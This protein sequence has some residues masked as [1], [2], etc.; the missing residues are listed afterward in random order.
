M[1]YNFETLLENTKLE[2]ERQKIESSR[3]KDD[4]RILYPGEVGYVKFR[5][6]YN[7][8]S[9]RVQREIIRH[10]ID[11]KKI[12]CLTMYGEEC[13][14]CKAVDDI[15]DSGS[16]DK[17]FRIYGRKTRGICY[18][19]FFGGSDS[20]SIG[21]NSYKD[22]ELVLMMYPKSVYNDLNKII[23]DSG[24]HI[25]DLVAN[26]ESVLLKL[27]KSSV[28]DRISYSLQVS[29]FDKRPSFSSTDEFQFFLEGIGDITNSV[30]PSILTEEILSEANAAA[31]LL[32]SKYMRTVSPAEEVERILEEIN[33]PDDT[34]A[35]ADSSSDL[36]NFLI[37]SGTNADHPECYGHYEGTGADRCRECAFEVG[38]MLDT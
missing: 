31:D 26:N 21:E 24:D 6:L 22:G 1:N 10:N 2:V 8:K 12:P 37:D 11:G 23:L 34:E 38:C 19:Q 27:E 14:I 30:V 17:V 9:Q 36:S 32:Y 25:S 13:P 3:V 33:A 4:S 7:V 28:N 15:E 18:A 5:V 29:P 16:L 20:Y 35:P